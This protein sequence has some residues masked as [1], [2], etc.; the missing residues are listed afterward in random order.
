TMAPIFRQIFAPTG[1][2]NSVLRFLG[3]GALAHPWLAQSSTALFVIM[4]LT[5]W[6]FTGITFILYYAAMTQ[7]ET[8]IIEAARIDGAGAFRILTR[9]VWP[10]CRVTKIALAMLSVIG[11][12]KLFDWLYLFNRG[13]PNYA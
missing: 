11:A 5:I 12:L 2:L 4:A 1:Q 8:E 7:I 10:G 9:I 3:L 6:E 13:G